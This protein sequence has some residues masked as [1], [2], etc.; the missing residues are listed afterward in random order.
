[1]VRAFSRRRAE[2]TAELARLGASSAKAAAVA[3]LTTRKAKDYRITP[4]ALQQQWRERAADLGVDA[5][6]SRRCWT[7]QASLMCRPPRST[8]SPSSWP[9]RPG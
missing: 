9:V 8:G 6:K 5:E 3:T 4:T 2:I 1:V 7:A